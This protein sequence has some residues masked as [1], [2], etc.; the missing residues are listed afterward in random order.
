MSPGRLLL[1]GLA[2]LAAGGRARAAGTESGWREVR[3][4]HVVLLT[5][6][7]PADARRAALAVERTRA[8]MLATAWQGAR[9]TQPDHIEVV[10]FASGLDFERHFGRSIAGVT[11]TGRYPPRVTLY[12]T[13]ERWERRASLSLEESTSVLKHELA[14]HLAAYFYRRQPRWFAEGLAQFLETIRVSDDG[15]SVVMGAI[16]IEALQK[17]NRFRTFT[18]ADVLAWGGKFDEKGEAT[19]AGLYG[20]SWLLVHW[21]YN[22]H[23]R[24]L[25]SFQTLLAKGIA[26][27]KAWKVAFASLAQ[28]SID[29]ELNEYAR[30]GNYNEFTGSISVSDAEAVERSLTS[31]DA[32]AIKASVAL[33]AALTMVDSAPHRAEAEQELTAALADDPSNARALHLLADRVPPAEREGVAR[34]AV[35]A[36]PEDGLAWLSLG[37]A[38]WSKPGATADRDAAFRK[39]TELLPDHPVAFNSL[40]WTFL[41][42]GKP[43]EALPLAVTAV[44]L[45]PWV[46]AYQETLAASLAA[47]GR[48]TEAVAAQ[49]RAIEALAEQ[50]NPHAKAELQKRLETYEA[51]CQPGKA[52][53]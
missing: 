43:R 21:L 12:G 16:N 30:H 13:P 52:S 50:R 7:G 48:C 34:R 41:Q 42:E 27:D 33:T 47:V 2:L 18:V 9:L 37:E 40:A 3:T 19:I 49:S 31:A 5:D 51:S 29:R 11:T 23:P 53:P 4:P 45:A 10:V 39:A 24:E 17:Y 46:P 26:P 14:H 44:Q 6:L 36:H 8:A 28:E 38:L 15:K 32:H 35:A 20:L 25:A 22:V 1:V